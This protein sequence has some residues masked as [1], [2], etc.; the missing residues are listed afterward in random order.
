MVI[1]WQRII[2]Y[3][4]TEAISIQLLIREW[5]K[6][7]GWVHNLESALSKCQISIFVCIHVE[8]VPN[9]LGFQITYLFIWHLF[10]LFCSF[11]ACLCIV[12][13]NCL[14]VSLLFV[15]RDAE[16]RWLQGNIRFLEG[17][18]TKLA[19]EM[20]Q[21]TARVMVWLCLPS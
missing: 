19:K 15:E 14:G 18:Q 4:S 21:L 17:E 12:I 3:S 5:L 1:S 11:D 16:S 7:E 8:M 13:S 2:V 10:N 6:S 9:L 20:E